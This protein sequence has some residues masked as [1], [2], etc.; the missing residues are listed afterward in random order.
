M[1]KRTKINT[2]CWTTWFQRLIVPLWFL[3]GRPDPRFCD[4]TDGNTTTKK[5]SRV[6]VGAVSFW[7]KVENKPVCS[8]TMTRKKA[9]VIV[10]LL[11]KP[12]IAS[13]WVTKI[14]PRSKRINWRSGN[15]YVNRLM[16]LL[17]TVCFFPFLRN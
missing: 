6:S 16:D 8:S 12:H 2:I 15:T 5:K 9:A 1:L 11:N 7:F 13:Q 10:Q 17:V 3:D 14:H 4:D